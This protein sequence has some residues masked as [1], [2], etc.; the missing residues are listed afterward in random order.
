METVT[1]RDGAAIAFDRPGDGPPVI[2]VCGQSTDGSSNAGV[3]ALLA[4]DFTVFDYDR[5]G[6][7]DPA[8]PPPDN[9]RPC[10]RNRASLAPVST[11]S[12]QHFPRSEHWRLP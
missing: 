4:P 3:A 11:T 9:A 1:S 12:H 6:R 10:G 7:G 5:R 8:H 2:L